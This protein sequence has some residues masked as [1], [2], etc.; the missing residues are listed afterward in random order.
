MIHANSETTDSKEKN[1]GP[2]SSLD[3][4]SSSGA[5]DEPLDVIP[6]RFP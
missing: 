1:D 4:P 6:N 5:M 2:V 3:L